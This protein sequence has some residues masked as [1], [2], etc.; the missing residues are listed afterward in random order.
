MPHK[1]TMV[2]VLSRKIGEEI[3][4]DDRITIKIVD[5]EGPKIKIGVS[6][7]RDMPVHRKEVHEMIHI[8]DAARSPVTG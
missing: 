2:L 6:A 3:V 7:P 1:E 4:I 5:I 8:R